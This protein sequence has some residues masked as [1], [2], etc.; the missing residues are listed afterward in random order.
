MRMIEMIKEMVPNARPD[1]INCD[2][3]HAAF[4][5]MKHFFPDVEIRGCL[6]HLSQ[7]LTC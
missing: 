7:K 5:T 6:F 3:E 1:A 4:A 2:F